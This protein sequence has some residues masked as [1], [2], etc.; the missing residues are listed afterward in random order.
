MQLKDIAP[1]Y[2]IALLVGL[3]VYFMKFLPISYWVIL[4]LQIVTGTIVLFVV[5]KKSQLEE[6]LEVKEIT[7]QYISKFRKSKSST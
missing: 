7:L 2:G 6:Y 3:S 4:P 5:C 1:S